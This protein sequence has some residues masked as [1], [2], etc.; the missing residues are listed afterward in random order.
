MNGTVPE[1]PKP[2]HIALSWREAQ[3]FYILATDG[4]SRA[5]RDPDEAVIAIRAAIDP[6]LDDVPRGSC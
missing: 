5:F 1:A 2:A 3:G 6:R 4:A